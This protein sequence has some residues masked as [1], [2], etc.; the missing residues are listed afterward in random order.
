MTDLHAFVTGFV[1]NSAIDPEKTTANPVEARPEAD[2]DHH[3]I[4]FDRI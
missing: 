3:R 1:Q 2:R 4:G